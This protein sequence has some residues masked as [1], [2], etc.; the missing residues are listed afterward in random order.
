MTKTLARWTILQRQSLA[1]RFDVKPA[2]IDK[3]RVQYWTDGIHY[4]RCT[5]RLV[6][7]YY[8]VCYHELTHRGTPEEHLRW[9]T[10]NCVE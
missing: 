4:H 1:E 9:V 6:V 10:V 7:Y 5:P 3:W 8:E 2:T